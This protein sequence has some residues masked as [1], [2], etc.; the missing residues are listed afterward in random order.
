VAV[1]TAVEVF[2]LQIRM[3]EFVYISWDLWHC[4]A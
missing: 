4:S 2:I 3:D 1:S